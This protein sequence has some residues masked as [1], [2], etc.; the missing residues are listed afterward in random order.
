M[1]FIG[2]LL[3]LCNF[4]RRKKHKDFYSVFQFEHEARKIL[5]LN[6]YNFFAGG[7]GEELSLKENMASFDRLKLVPRV[8]KEINSCN[9][10]TQ[11]LGQNIS[12]PVLIAPM[13]FQ[14][15]A[16]AEGEL[17]VAKAVSLHGT[18]M[19]VS[20]LS[21]SSLKDIKESSSIS[22]WFQ[23]YIYK[24]REITKNL[25]KQAD[26]LN[27]GAIVLTVDTP[28]YA[29]RMRELQNPISLKSYSQVVNLVEA[30]LKL[31]SINPS[32]LPQYLSSLLESNIG[33]KDI[34]WIRSITSLP[35]IL[36]GILHPEDMQIAIDHNIQGVILSNH[37]GRQLDTAI[38]AL[39]ALLLVKE[40]T[41]NEIDIIVDGGIRKGSDILKALALGAKAVM[42]GRPIIWGLGV[43]GENGVH[44]VLGILKK[45]LCISMA[46]TGTASI[47]SLDGNIIKN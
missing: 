4:D 36:K 26:K 28:F 9:L 8:L 21:T 18:I 42:V 30:G 7:A 45:E 33:W 11:L 44:Q 40:S 38:T 35:I 41:K 20:T 32:I 29:K 39:E 5:P 17:A 19:T 12:F 37:G 15:L 34:E 27:Y 47:R 16:H 31:D 10:S 46:L 3:E 25:I 22:P 43:N 1:H 23:V 14:N 24:D 6:I 13:A 2:K